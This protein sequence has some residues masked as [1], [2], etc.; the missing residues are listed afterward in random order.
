MREQLLL[1]QLEFQRRGPLSASDIGLALK[2]SQPSVSRLL[3]RLG[4]KGVRLGRGKSTRYAMVREIGPL[5]SEWP[6]Y[7]IDAHGKPHRV[8][9]LHALQ[10][11]QWCLQQDAPWD[12][13]RAADFPHGLYPDLPWFL[14]DLRPQGF[15]GRT[16]A[17]V[18]GQGLGAPAD[19]RSW[20]ADL[21]VEALLRYGHDLQGSFVLGEAMLAEA[22]NRMLNTKDAVPAA[23]RLTA[24]PKLADT[25][26]AG[27]WPGSSAGGG[28]TKIHRAPPRTQRCCPPCHR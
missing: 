25:M 26:L 20:S 19:P 14:D 11:S 15:L 1:L 23:S 12:S 3:K 18:F 16:F 13:L 24:Y 6:L 21:V 27:E 22:Q 2:I 5:G 7:E 9:I 8:G 17:R 4:R 10:P 28:A